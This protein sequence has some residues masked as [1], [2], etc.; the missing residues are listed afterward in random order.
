[1]LNQ[2]EAEAKLS[3]RD[4]SQ[5]KTEIIDGRTIT[6]TTKFR[7]IKGADYAKIVLAQSAL[8]KSAILGSRGIEEETAAEEPLRRIEYGW[9]PTRRQPDADSDEENRFIP[10]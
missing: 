5:T 4:V 6:T 3:V 7:A 1:M 9:V 2:Y 8:I 10:S